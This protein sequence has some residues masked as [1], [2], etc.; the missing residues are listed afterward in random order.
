MTAARPNS[1]PFDAAQVEAR[2]M[3]STASPAGRRVILEPP[4]DHAPLPLTINPY[5]ERLV[6]ASR[7]LRA[8]L[9]HMENPPAPLSERAQRLLSHQTSRLSRAV[10]RLLIASRHHDEEHRAPLRHAQSYPAA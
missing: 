2:M 7:L 4:G 1:G 3:R 6:R 8:R 10:E 5:S 9:N